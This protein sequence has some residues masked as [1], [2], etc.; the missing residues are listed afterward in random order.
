[1]RT[2][3]QLGDYIAPPRPASWFSSGH[4]TVV[5]GRKEKGKEGGNGK[6]RCWER[7]PRLFYNLTTDDD[8]DDDDDDH[9]VDDDDGFRG[10]T[11]AVNRT[12]QNNRRT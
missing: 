7:S 3:F 6:E 11:Y 8:D 5:E 1:M 2:I 12:R 10:G 4:F 9:D